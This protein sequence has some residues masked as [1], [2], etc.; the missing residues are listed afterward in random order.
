MARVAGK[1]L[2][3]G[4]PIGESWELSDRNPV[5][6]GPLAGRTLDELVRAHPVEIVGRRGVKRFPLLVKLIDA[7]EWL[8]VQVHPDDAC[9]RRMKVSPEGKTEAWY[10]LNAQPGAK[11]IA[12]LRRPDVAARLIE[13]AQSGE[14]VNHLRRVAPKAGEVWFCPA[15][16]VHALGPGLILLEIQQNTDVTF[17]LYDWGRVG[18][19]GKPRQLHLAESARAVG[20]GTKSVTRCA[21]KT[22]RGLGVPARR[23]VSCDKFVI[24]DWRISRAVRRRKEGGFEVLHV[25]E[26]AG[27]LRCAEWPEV[28]LRKGM[29]VLVPAG[30]AEY[31]ILPAR[32]L[33]IIRSAEGE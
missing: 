24:D 21:G 30:V 25:A 19:D 26:G 8:S 20:D 10:F 32:A 15:G 12:G 29:T 2:P 4:P 3:P 14:I 27:A 28:R 6:E 9:A 5:R 31:D 33:H 23:R 22:L 7:Q 18:L 16:G 13:L 1:R 11:M 17:R